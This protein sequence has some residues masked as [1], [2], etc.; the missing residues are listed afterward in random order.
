MSDTQ[1]I[2]I[3]LGGWKAVV[4]GVI[5]LAVGTFFFLKSRSMS[6]EDLQAVVQILESDYAR[7]GLG[8]VKAA[9]ATGA[10]PAAPAEEMLARSG[11]VRLT[12]IRAKG[13]STEPIVRVEIEV[14]GK[15]PPDGRPVR[16]FHMR[17]STLTGWRCV[18]E[19]T[20]FAYY[21][22]FF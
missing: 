6:Q 22:R 20:A 14:D 2:R 13:S 16:Y 21:T 11:R 9:M 5:A 19:T 12:S 10:D 4:V 8:E 3:R 1:E 7:H 18:R 17:Y 15:E